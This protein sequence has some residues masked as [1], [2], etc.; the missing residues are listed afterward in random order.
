MG[1]CVCRDLMAEIKLKHL[2][3]FNTASGTLLFVPSS[4]LASLLGEPYWIDRKEFFVGHFR[5]LRPI[6]QTFEQSKTNSDFPDWPNL[7]EPEKP[8]VDIQAIES[9]VEKKL[10]TVNPMDDIL[11]RDFVS[12]QFLLDCVDEIKTTDDIEETLHETAEY[13]LCEHYYNPTYAVIYGE[14]ILVLVEPNRFKI[15]AQV[16]ANN[17]VIGGR[18][19]PLKIKAPAFRVTEE[20]LRKL[21]RHLLPRP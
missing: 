19:V 12:N 13:L 11:V 15:F 6:F 7:F 18:I 10:Y 1:S 14:D 21:A 17:R 8:R 3:A 9:C 16:D 5:D 20:A 2:S 4:K